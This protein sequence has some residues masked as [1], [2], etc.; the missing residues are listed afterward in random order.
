MDFGHGRPLLISPSSAAITARYPLTTTH[1]PPLGGAAVGPAESTHS[2][3]SRPE[4]LMGGAGP[5]RDVSEPGT[6]CEPPC[7][8]GAVWSAAAMGHLAV[9]LLLA[10]ELPYP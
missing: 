1:F 10:M 9:M 4:L 8:P 7:E 5:R 6:V 3:A 2:R